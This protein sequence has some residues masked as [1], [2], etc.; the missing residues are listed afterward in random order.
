MNSVGDNYKMLVT[1]LAMSTT[2]MHYIFTS[3]SGSN[4]SMKKKEMLKSTF[5]E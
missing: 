5:T 2:N 1:F 4:I 3:E